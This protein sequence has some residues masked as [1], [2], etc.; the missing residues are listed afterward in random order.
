MNEKITAQDEQKVMNALNR[1]APGMT[2]DE[3]GRKSKLGGSKLSA[4][5][6]AL[7][8]KGHIHQNAMKYFLQKSLEGFKEPEEQ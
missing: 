2:F 7:V 6:E 8:R 3:V 4:I 5:L 1:K